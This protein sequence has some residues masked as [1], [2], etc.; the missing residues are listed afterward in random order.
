MVDNKVSN[1]LIPNVSKVPGNKKVDLRDRLGG[2][3][4]A[5]NRDEFKNL[6]KTEI[7]SEIKDVQA[8]HGINLSVHAAKRLKERN[9]DLD[10]NE[11]FKLR[12]AME[13]LRTKGGR[14]SLVITD[15]AAYIV[16]VPGNKVVTAID[17]GS[18]QENVFTKIDST[19][20][21]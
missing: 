19:V 15:K 4:G 8:Q 3:E 11:F 12:G 17:K 5:E 7:E 1:F 18:I 20:V 10:T 16:D 6:L 13:K 21:V 2:A 14:D 9:L